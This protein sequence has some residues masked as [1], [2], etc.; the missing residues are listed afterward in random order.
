MTIEVKPLRP[1]QNST[2]QRM[3]DGKKHIVLLRMGMGKTVVSMKAI[4]DINNVNDSNLQPSR[5]NKILLLCRRNGISGWIEHLKAWLPTLAQQQGVTWRGIHIFVQ[6]KDKAK[7]SATWLQRFNFDDGIL[8][9]FIMTHQC[10]VF[11]APELHKSVT[12]QPFDLVIIDEAKRLFTTHVSRHQL[13]KALKPICRLATYVWPMTGSRPRHPG[14]AFTCLN[15]VDPTTFSSYWQ[16]LNTFT[17]FINTQGAGTEILGIKNPEQWN[18]IINAKM[19]ILGPE[20][21]PGE[22]PQRQ[23]TLLKVQ[24]TSEQERI[25]NDFNTDSMSFL[26]TAD[27]LLITKNSLEKLVRWRQLFICPKIL[28][29]SLGWG[30]ALEDL[31]DQ[32]EELDSAPAV[33][34]TPYKRALPYIDQ[35]LKSRGHPHIYHLHGGLPLEELERRRSAYKASNGIILCTILYATSFEL[36]PALHCFFL[37]REWDPED[38]EQAEYR[39]IRQDNV[40]RLPINAYYYCYQ[41]TEDENLCEEVAIKQI[42]INDTIDLNA[43]KRR[44]VGAN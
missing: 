39:L 40:S 32:L 14:Y 28:D 24:M 43:L 30:A 42:L 15:L 26:P 44:Y 9:V 18:R 6:P 36:Q 10:A 2:T 13:F 19:T 29:P 7:R 25:Y 4:H 3:V 16:T 8:R 20:D 12:H 5:I 31:G 41:D 11:D 37:D 35:Y 22:M 33:I 21:V 17:I 23:R 1:Y 38:N 27:R 34:Y